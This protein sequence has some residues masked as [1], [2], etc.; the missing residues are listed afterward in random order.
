MIAHNM[1]NF[2]NLA[3]NFSRYIFTH[4]KMS[5][6][7]EYFFDINK[8]ED[9]ISIVHF[10]EFEEKCKRLGEVYMKSDANKIRK[11]VLRRNLF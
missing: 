1:R 2:L 4:D 3:F 6:K 7:I 9:E 10:L 8:L 5:N 11:Y